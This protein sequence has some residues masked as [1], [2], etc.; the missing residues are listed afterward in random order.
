M[1]PIRLLPVVSL[2]ALCLLAFATPVPAG[3]PFYLTAERSFSSSEAPSI[4]LDYTETIKPMVIRV[5]RP[6]NLEQFLEGQFRISRSYEEPVSE[7]NPGHYFIKGL[8]KVE[9]PLMVF[10][11]MLD[12][13]FRKSFNDTPV[14]DSIV[15]THQGATI[16]P[17]EQV[18]HGPPAGFKT[19]H[20]YYLDFQFG[21]QN[22]S[23]LG[24]W[25]GEGYWREQSYKIR[26][27]TLDPL[28][29][30]VYL[31]QAVQ[32]I[33]EAQC[34][35]QVSSLSVQVKQSS[36]QFVVRVIDRDSNP[37]AQA[38]ISYRDS[39]GKWVKS[40][41]VTDKFGQA[42][43]SSSD[44][45][46][47]GKLLIRAET[48]EGRT[49]L[50]DTDFLPVT[51]TG[52]SVF[53]VT[54]RP[55]FKPGEN[56]SFKGIVRSLEKGQ[57]KVPDP[58][59][60]EARIS[61]VRSD[62]APT[63]LHANVPMSEFGSFSGTLGLDDAQPPGLYKLVARIGAKPY[64]GEFRVR[65]YIKPV[66][67]LELIDR[68]PTVTQG[69][70][71]F[72]KFRARRYSGGVPR[73]LKYEVFLYRKKFD[74]PQFVL[75]AG[76]GLGTEGDYFG[77]VRSASSLAEPMRV[78]SSVEARLSDNSDYGL[79]NTWDSAP[80]VGETGE[81]SYEFEVPRIESAA[82]SGKKATESGP[83]ARDE[84]EWIYTFVV[85]A[86]NRA[87][88][89]AV[90][91][92]NIYA[93]LS[94]AQPAVRFSEQTAQAGDKGQWILVRSTYSD[95]KPAPRA[96]GIVNL[97][98][99]QDKGDAKAFAELAFT[100]DDQ[101]VCK[102]ALP[103]LDTK[104][105]LSTVAMLDTLDGKPMRHPARSAPASMIV[106]GAGGEAILDNEELELHTATGILSP[107]EKAKV[108]ALLPAGWGKSESG[109]VW[110]TISGRRIYETRPLSFQGRSCWFEVEARPE[111]GTGF[112]HTI[113]VPAGG[114]KYREQTLGF[115]I[116][117]RD[118]VLAVAAFPERE[119]TEALKPFKIDFEVKDS[120]GRPAAQTELAV[121]IVNLAVYA[122]QTEIRPPILDFFYP[123]PKQNLAT[124]YS[125][126]LQGYGYAA[127]LKKPNFKLGAL[128][129]Q[130]KPTKKALRDTAGWF[131]HV[132]TDAD[133]RASVT[134][135]MPAN[136]TEWL[137]TAIAA[138]KQGRVGESVK[139]FR[140]VS[141]TSVEVF[142]P[143]FMREGE[144][145][146]IMV[147][148]IN[149]LPQTLAV[150]SQI[151]VSGQTSTADKQLERQFTVEANGESLQPLLIEAAKGEGMGIVRVALEAA[152]DVR[153]GG[154]E[155]FEIPVKPAA[156][157]QSFAA[158]RK[159][160]RLETDLP[161]A[162][163]IRELKV[164]VSP[165]LLG[166]AL[167]AS[168]AL[169]S[170]PYG[171]TEQLVDTTV[172]NLV[173]MDLI[174]KAGI[175]HDQLGPLAQSLVRAESNAAL[176][177]KK[178][179]QNQKSD[180][181]FGLWPGDSESSIPVTLTALYALKFAE[182]L[183]IEGASQAY[184]QGMSWLSRQSKGRGAIRCT[185][186]L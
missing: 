49:A 124:F 186:G 133:G 159:E 39:K 9:S 57:L 91:S 48:P 70:R 120:Q 31:L 29:D 181:G 45:M 136:I 82:Q 10:R 104:G 38:A 19:V 106:G 111:Y 76:G 144:K 138:D 173:L 157:R 100:T 172:P 51:S 43:L 113:T 125:D 80:V 40:D 122:V 74:V 142:S 86:V 61:L 98:V 149:Y 17:P 33:T 129:S 41:M 65:D 15:E 112:Y 46:F 107:G 169:V 174:G 131:P 4:R 160:N 97:T 42:V 63:D 26:H 89:Q 150:K 36:E 5:L 90:L 175:A 34:L 115:R 73:E 123:L 22:V 53:I 139:K 128:K 102:I 64:G 55:I 60:K 12:P 18:I 78:F 143:Q 14:H 6:N 88:A 62:G 56:F 77:K 155:E 25:F 171:C 145:A 59:E 85:R 20:E 108:L 69:E 11:R 158:V 135:D 8:N 35:M 103:E 161:R 24:W 185:P 30:G 7:L 27:I 117:P 68:S 83:V 146:S 152:R 168:A 110:E 179:R 184:A 148:T 130:S 93:T 54:D 163:G 94:E 114:G 71:F 72:I 44:G 109:T 166:A 3:S 101:G 28:P 167:N 23:D 16:S 2:I 13:G 182:N 21:G 66:F 141:D 183:K 137:I 140:T 119:E 153:V 32:G 67:Y 58:T 99:K 127:I 177:I 52:D 170:Y 156:M 162:A 180:G 178:I 147:K 164:Q 151:E 154:A 118:K 1:K 105:R 84:G 176:G 79:M 47:D 81:A 87:G 121:T 126:E 50:V 116:V 134:V 165:G 75:E 95:G 96:G 92:G 132:V 37:V